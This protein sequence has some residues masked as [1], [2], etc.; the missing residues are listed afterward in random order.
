MRT[1]ETVSSLTG[2][3]SSCAYSIVLPRMGEEM[4]GRHWY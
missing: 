3:R 1:T 4:C 2:T